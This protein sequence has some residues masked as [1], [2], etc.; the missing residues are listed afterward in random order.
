LRV[1]DRASVVAAVDYSVNGGKGW[2]A[3]LPSDNIFDS[4]EEAVSFTAPG[5]AAG[6]VNQITVRATD[7]KGNQAY[8]S[9]TVTLE[10][11]AAK[12]E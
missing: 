1:I 12:S 5:L 9:V 4:P 8:E 3:V 11:A 7:A 6:S 2:Q 10:G